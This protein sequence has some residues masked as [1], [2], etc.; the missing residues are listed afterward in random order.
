MAQL[1]R[2]LVSDAKEL[3]RLN[4]ALAKRGNVR[5]IKE[6]SLSNET[7]RELVKQ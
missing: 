2:T 6:K 5:W 1:V 4:Q 7:S 3:L